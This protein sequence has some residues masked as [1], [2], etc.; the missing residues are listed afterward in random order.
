[1]LPPLQSTQTDSSDRQTAPDRSDSS[2]SDGSGLIT[3]YVMAEEEL[4]GECLQCR[5]R[6]GLQALLLLRLDHPA[7]LQ[8]VPL[9]FL[10]PL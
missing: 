9:H 5:G 8:Q 10:R 7:G 6:A 4:L 2:R 1:M 3:T